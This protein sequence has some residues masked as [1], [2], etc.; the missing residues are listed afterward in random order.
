MKHK[1]ATLKKMTLAALLLVLS[2]FLLPALAE[3][4]TGE[5]GQAGE[6]P[7]NLTLRLNWVG[8][9]EETNFRPD[10]VRVYIKKNGENL[11]S[12]YSVK[13]EN[14]WET[15]LTL[16][17]VDS[18]GNACDYALNRIETMIWPVYIVTDSSFE[19]GMLTI[20]LT[21]QPTV[22]IDAALQWDD[23]NDI[24]GQRPKE[25]EPKNITLYDDYS[26]RNV[27]V[28]A[29][30]ME[31]NEDGSWTLHFK[32]VPTY[33]TDL[34]GVLQPVKSYAIDAKGADELKPF[35][36]EQS[37]STPN[38]EKGKW[39]STRAYLLTA[40]LQAIKVKANYTLQSY[41]KGGYASVSNN[42]TAW[43]YAQSQGINVPKMV[44]MTVLSNGKPIERKD[45]TVTY[46]R[47]EKGA[48]PTM[49]K[50][51]F[52]PKYDANGSEID[53]GEISV[54]YSPRQGV[55]LDG[56]Y[57][58]Y[59]Q[60]YWTASSDKNNHYIKTIIPGTGSV[61]MPVVW[62]DDS[63]ALNVRP[64]T[65]SATLLAD[66]KPVGG[67]TTL[68]VKAD[69]SLTGYPGAWASLPQR[70]KE[71]KYIRYS[72]QLNDLPAYYDAQTTENPTYNTP[73]TGYNTNGSSQTYVSK[74]EE[75]TTFTLKTQTAKAT[76]K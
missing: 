11:N 65:I 59:V 50:T 27:E 49:E 5:N 56:E 34:K 19:N 4:K 44:S 60:E 38:Y 53:Y 10:M 16:P 26:R 46:Q 58:E 3:Q 36:S 21:H 71:G 55:D 72:F 33:Y 22:N 25:L 14:K 45:T 51:W 15:T 61:S 23:D 17:L 43:K 30:S 18:E 39:Y 20:T 29:E 73:E 41:L 9:E 54:D 48:F 1:R 12:L 62:N 31:K 75:K 6:A 8:D 67:A 52:L 76:I 24:N 57:G 68:K 37:G 7:Q 74:V 28:P 66:G 35:Y 42:D 40:R 64:N 13:R 47:D 2:L 32:N 70:S 63:N 69:G